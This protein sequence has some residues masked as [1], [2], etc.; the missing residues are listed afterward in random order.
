M[1]PALLTNAAV[2]GAVSVDAG[3]RRLRRGRGRA[4][5]AEHQRA[6]RRQHG[7]EGC[8]TIGDGCGWTG[9]TRTGWNV[10][11]PRAP[12]QIRGMDAAGIA[13]LVPR[14]ASEAGGAFTTRNTV[15]PHVGRGGAHQASPG[16]SGTADG[17]KR[18]REPSAFFQ[19]TPSSSGAPRSPQF[20][21]HLMRDPVNRPLRATAAGTRR[22]FR[23]PRH[24]KI[25]HQVFVEAG[26]GAVPAG[27][28][29]G[30]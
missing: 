21:L 6:R 15:S 30:G 22:P 16:T 20:R 23:A 11:R 7:L 9:E 27:I 25:A 5:A 29:A 13:D 3:A 26:S 10:R 12:V 17:W 19:G 18:G 14:R 8:H 1:P 28:A 2:A 4:R 24:C